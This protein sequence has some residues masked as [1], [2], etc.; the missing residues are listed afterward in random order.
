ME[1]LSALSLF[2]NIVDICSRTVKVCTECREIYRSTKGRREQDEEL[3]RYLGDFQQSLNSLR[4]SSSKVNRD[5]LCK[6]VVGPPLER[7]EA[8]SAAIKDMLEGFRAKKPG[9]HLATAIA[10]ANVILGQRQLDRGVQ[11]LK[12][13]QN[14][15]HFAIAQSTR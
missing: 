12:H 6:S 13:C 10:A 1:P 5:D 11:E 9:N 14:D 15:I 8:K 2:C 7:M 4:A 3:L